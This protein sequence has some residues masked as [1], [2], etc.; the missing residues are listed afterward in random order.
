MKSLA[1]FVFTIFIPVLVFA[2]SLERPIETQ[3]I[4]YKAGPLTMN[5]FLAR[6]KDLKKKVPGI[7]VV[8]EWW[9]QTDY[10]R[11]RA[12]MLAHLGYVAMAVDMYGGGRIADHPKTAGEFSSAVMRDAKIVGSRFKAAYN[13]LKTQ[14]DVDPK[15]IAAFGYCFGGSVVMEM[16]KQGLDLIGVVS[17][18]GGLQTPTKA[19]PDRIKAEFLVFNGANDKFVSPKAIAKF[20]QNMTAAHAKFKFENMAGS[21]HG[22]T[23]PKATEFGKKFK[24]PIAYNAEADKKS[25]HEAQEFL[26][27]IF[28]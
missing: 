11:K 25:L 3:S 12:K 20:K 18:H 23:N 19:M 15:K 6:P 10:P 13:T 28:R 22:F 24:L 8:H 17:F 16:G 14:K 27:R 9:G 26:K 5:G 2:A 21:V 1:V 4:T 7:L